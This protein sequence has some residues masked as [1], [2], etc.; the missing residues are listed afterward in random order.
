MYAETMNEAFMR[1]RPVLPLIVTMSLPMVLSMLVN[2]LY[3]IV[4]SFFVAQISEASMTALSLVYPIQNLVNA[5]AIGFGVG[6]NAAISC[7]LGSE[8]RDRASAAAVHGLALSAVHGVVLT[9]LTIVL[10]PSFLEMFTQDPEVLEL[11]VRYGRTVFCFSLLL[12]LGLAYEKIFQ[13]VGRMKVPMA[14]LL[15]GCLTN[16]ILDPLLIFGPGPFPKLGI[17]GAALATGIGQTLTLLVYLAVW[18]S[19]ALPVTLS[20]R[21]LAWD[22]RLDLRLYSVG[23]PATLSLALPSLLISALNS[24]LSA[25]SPIYV[26]ILGIYY[27]LQTFL[28]LPASGIVQ[29]MRPVIGYNYGAGEQGRVREIYRV[30]LGLCAAIMAAGTVLCLAIP[31]QLMG[32]FTQNPESIRAGAEALRIISAGFLVSSV[33]VAAGGALEGLG[34]GGPSLVISLLRYTLVMIPAA[35]LLSRLIGPAGVWHAFWLS[36]AVTALLSIL[37]Y[38]R[39]VR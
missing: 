33:S 32:L 31:A 29:G 3:N 24:I 5:L 18:R 23:I 21:A 34:K 39:S 38:R 6:L 27:K 28:Y 26:V 20:R 9:G 22:W 16:I 17:E 15:T 35:W 11:G 1:E 36:E 14:A 37:I 10:L 7:Y 30:T 19:C 12:S 4:D 2:S 8:R 13:A 25:F